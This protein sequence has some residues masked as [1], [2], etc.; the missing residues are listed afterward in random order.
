M[1]IEIIIMSALVFIIIIFLSMAFNVKETPV[2]FLYILSAGLFTMI[3]LNSAIAIARDN[4]SSAG[5]I[6]MLTTSYALFMWIFI[7]GFFL[8]GILFVVSAVSNY[9]KRKEEEDD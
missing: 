9:K 3:A 6:K 4:N 2:K 1:A 8:S 5:I 7:V